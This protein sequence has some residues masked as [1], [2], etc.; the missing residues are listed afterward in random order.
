MNVSEYIYVYA[1]HEDEQ[2]LCELELRTLLSA[3]PRGRYA[4]SPRPVDPSRSP[5]I[6]LRLGVW[7]EAGSL[8]ELAERVA[9]LQ[10]EAASFKV[11][12]AETDDTV[13]YAA[14]RAIERELGLRVRGR[15]EMHR[16]ARRFA[17]AVLG[18]GRW[19]F[20]DCLLAEPIWLRHQQKP[21][22]YST[23][24]GT[25][26]ARAVVNLAAPETAGARL[27]DPCCGM[28]TVLIEAMSMGIDI[29]GFDLNPLAVRGARVNLA[30]FGCPEGAVTL[31]DMRQVGGAYTALVLDMPYNLCSVLPE[32]EQAEMLAAARRLA[33]RAV[34]V[35]T[36][37]LGDAVERAGFR[38]AGRCTVRK[39]RFARHIYVC[40]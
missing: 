26:V 29:V 4:Q 36:A 37:E 21:Q 14:R 24:L 17:A 30:H 38:I 31:A 10:I 11:S 18:G 25:R 3:E 2:E 39:G 23:A 34:V 28:G 7:C 16:P 1:C 8:P 20:G 19:V 35:A 15:A 9:A 13:S 40:E 33:S 6:K 32:A 12:F 22:N 27:I 5:F